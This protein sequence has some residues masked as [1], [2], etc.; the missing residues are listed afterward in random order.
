VLLG[1]LYRLTQPTIACNSIIKKIIVIFRKFHKRDNYQLSTVNYQLSTALASLQTTTEG[2]ENGHHS[3]FRETVQARAIKDPVFRV[4]LL[5]EGIESLL[6]GD[7]ATGKSLLRDYINAT[8]GFEKLSTLTQKSP[9]SLMRM[10][11]PNGNPTAQNL[12]TVIHTLQQQEG[13]QFQVNTIQ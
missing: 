11:G 7:V 6:S 2:I 12:F 1:F 10:F 13:V 4:G 9:Q 5:R 3:F 8:I